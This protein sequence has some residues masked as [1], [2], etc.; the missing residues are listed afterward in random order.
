MKVV[1]NACYGGF[2]LSEKAF[3]R[4]IELGMTVT[5]FNRKGNYNNPKADISERDEK[6]KFFKYS[7]MIG[8]YSL[9]HDKSDIAIRTDPRIIK[10]VEELG[11]EADG[12]CS[13]LKIVQVPDDANV[14]I[15]EYDGNEWVAEVHRRWD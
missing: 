6:D 5:K 14:T 10:V 11:E 8:K 12:F 15:E 3:K 7:K 9:V 2:N 13:Q 1:I 4:L